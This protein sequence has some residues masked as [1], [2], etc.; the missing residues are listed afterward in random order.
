MLTDSAF[1]QSA[2][3]VLGA[4]TLALM[5]QARLVTTPAPHP[6]A[7][8]ARRFLSVLDVYLTTTLWIL[9][10]GT[11]YLLFRHLATNTGALTTANRRWIEWL[12]LLQLAGLGSISLINRVVPLLWTAP[13][14][15]YLEPR[16]DYDMVG[17]LILALFTALSAAA[18]LLLLT[19][20]FEAQ[21]LVFFGLGAFAQG[22]YHLGHRVTSPLDRRTAR[23]WD[24]QTMRH[25]YLTAA[26][27]VELPAGFDPIAVMGLR[28]APQAGVEFL[29]FDEAARLVRHL[30]GARR[31]GIR[32]H[33][34]AS[35]LP[36]LRLQLSLRNWGWIVVARDRTRLPWVSN[37][38]AH[39]PRGFV[40]WDG[41]CLPRLSDTDREPPVC[42][43]EQSASRRPASHP[44]VDLRAARDAAARS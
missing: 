35:V 29:A 19:G 26:V 37:R 16:L 18:P 17:K 39:A 42:P 1:S 9:A 5:L 3:T 36:P 7:R 44:Q 27:T 41:Y 14:A 28:R 10:L 25:G 15:R 40:R 34:S 31:F 2:V 22:L 43:S 30:N 23:Y 21:V 12:L 24:A 8:R 32:E 20:H 33:P 38:P 4:S 11:G 6:I 13:E